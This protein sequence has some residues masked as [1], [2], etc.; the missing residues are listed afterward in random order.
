LQA[1]PCS[2]PSVIAKKKTSTN[3]RLVDAPFVV[4]L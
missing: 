2:I 1:P 4:P 3:L